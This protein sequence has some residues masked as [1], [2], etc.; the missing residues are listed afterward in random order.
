M[1]VVS[2]SSPLIG[3]EQIGQLDLLRSLFRQVLKDDPEYIVR[4]VVRSCA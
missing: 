3:L 2:N 4:L 1:P